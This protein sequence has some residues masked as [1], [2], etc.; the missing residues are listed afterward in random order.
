MRHREVDAVKVVDQ[1]AE[2]EQKGNSPPP[3]RN[4]L[5]GW[6]ANVASQIVRQ[7]LSTPPTPPLVQRPR[8]VTDGDR[9]FYTPDSRQLWKIQCHSARNSSPFIR[10]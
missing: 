10:L 1:Y 3:P 5:A 4:S 9:V 8:P 6:S 7:W 2:P